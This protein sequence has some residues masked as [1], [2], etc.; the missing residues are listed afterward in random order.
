MRTGAR[1]E[2]VVC[3]RNLDFGRTRVDRPVLRA[4]A[5][6]VVAV[7]SHLVNFNHHWLS[8]EDTYIWTGVPLAKTPPLTSRHLA[9]LPLG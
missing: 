5:V 3:A 8:V 6:A 2:T 4:G 7:G 1:I 9:L